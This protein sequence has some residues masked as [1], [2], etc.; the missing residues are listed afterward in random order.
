MKKVNLLSVLFLLIP[1][2]SLAQQH[3][4]QNQNSNDSVV[5][6]DSTQSLT[7]PK[8]STTSRFVLFWKDFFSADSKLPFNTTNDNNYV[9]YQ[10]LVPFEPDGVKM[11]HI[12]NG[13]FFHYKRPTSK[14]GVWST[15]WV[16][17]KPKWAQGLIGIM[18]RSHVGGGILEIGLGTALELDDDPIRG[19]A[20]VTY[21]DKSER[22]TAIATFEYG[23][24]GHWYLA[25]VNYRLTKMLSLGLH[26]QCSA[27]IGG[28]GSLYL[29]ERLVISAIVGINAESS[30]HEYRYGN[31]HIQF[32]IIG[33]LRYNFIKGH[34]K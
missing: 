7:S 27:A 33:G 14:W 18:R 12:L 32:A 25:S 6:K 30:Y 4:H 8:D 1:F 28:R 21:E 20:L 5:S 17:V 24:S 15:F 31:K 9:E 19:S 2:S 22:L 29:T 10:E 11:E 23:G 16:E 26:A 13:Y 34:L 3:E